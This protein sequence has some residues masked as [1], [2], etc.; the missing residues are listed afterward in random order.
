MGVV[1]ERATKPRID[2]PPF[3]HP[4][5]TGVSGFVTRPAY[6][7]QKLLEIS[8]CVVRFGPR[9]RADLQLL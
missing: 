4:F 7:I 8:A 9:L 1:I 2:V 3:S 6:L 5:I